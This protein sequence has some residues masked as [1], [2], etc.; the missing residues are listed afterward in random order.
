MKG[1]EQRMENKQ[2]QKDVVESVESEKEK[3]ETV[4]NYGI[5]L[6]TR[7]QQKREVEVGRLS[8]Q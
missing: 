6:V 4:V 8:K 2:K 1:N 7:E 3:H 5:I